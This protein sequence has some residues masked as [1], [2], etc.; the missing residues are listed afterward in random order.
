MYYKIYSNLLGIC[1]KKIHAVFLCM[2]WGMPV[3]GYAEAYRQENAQV[4]IDILQA[5]YRDANF[6]FL[7]TESGVYAL[8]DD[9]KILIQPTG[10]CPQ[11]SPDAKQDPPLCALFAF[12]YPA[13]TAGRYPG[14]GFD[15]GRIRNQ[16]L[17]KKLYG[18]NKNAVASNCVMVNFLGKRMAFNQKHGAAAALSRVSA[19]LEKMLH[20]APDLKQYI[21][22]L[23]GT[24]SWRTIKNSKRLSAHSFAIAIDL[25]V[26][27]GIY[28]LWNPPPT[29]EQIELSRKNYPQAIIDAF[30]AE[31]FI[32]G[33]KWHA[34]DFMHFEYRPEMFAIP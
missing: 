13:G 10:P 3:S 23:A 22:P 27:K 5:A 20:N 26:D 33:G 24:F 7:K 15:P 32:W 9:E 1:K 31:G 29:V 17:L 2:V 18:S 8:I 28:W 12:K 19:R 30:E 21:F 11:I 6:Q 34:F 14:E 25:N 4:Y 16:P